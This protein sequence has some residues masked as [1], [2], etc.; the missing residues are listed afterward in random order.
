MS[1]LLFTVMATLALLFSGVGVASGETQQC[2]DA[3]QAVVNLKN[4][5]ASL[6]PS[7]QAYLNPL[8]ANAQAAVQ[9]Y[10]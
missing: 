1:K 9:K 4:Y 10:C 2:K 7:H 3:K 5:Q 8:I 6:P